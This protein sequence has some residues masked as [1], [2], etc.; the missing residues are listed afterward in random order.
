MCLE[1]PRVLQPCSSSMA[2]FLASCKFELNSSLLGR[3]RHWTAQHETPGARA[4]SS[5][6]RFH[7]SSTPPVKFEPNSSKR[8]LAGAPAALDRPTPG[9]RSSPQ[10][11]RATIRPK[12]HPTGQLRVEFE[13]V[14]GTGSIR[15]SKTPEARAKPICKLDA[16][17][18][19]TPQRSSSSRTRTSLRLRWRRR[20]WTAQHET[21]AARAKSSVPR[22]HPSSTSTVKVDPNS[23]LRGRQRQWT[24]QR[25]TPRARAKS[26]MPRF[27]PAAHHR[28]SWSRI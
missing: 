23:S 22:F 15:P 12:Q 4:K 7:P 27:D 25:Q 5:V 10:V 9:P 21:P 26:S 3:Q 16:I 28:S 6:P 14:G 19:T 20:H 2:F 1:C 8:E 24:A 17:H 18:P 11:N 13:L